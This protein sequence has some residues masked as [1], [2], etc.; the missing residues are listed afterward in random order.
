MK[1]EI[2]GL[3]GQRISKEQATVRRISPDRAQVYVK[4]VERYAMLFDRPEVRLRFLNNMI[5]KQVVRQKKLQHALRHFRF[6]ERTRLYDILLDVRF[7]R[8]IM[9]ELSASAGAVPIHRSKYFRNIR[10]PLTARTGFFCYQFRHAIYGTGLML[11]LLMVFGMYSLVGWSVGRVDKLL[12]KYY[13]PGSSEVLRQG[14][15]AAM[16]R[17][18]RPKE[19]E[20]TPAKLEKVWFLDK[21]GN[22]ERWSNRA[23][24]RTE[25]ETENRPRRFYAIPRGSDTAP[26]RLRSDIVGIVYHTSESHI[27]PY[28]PGYSEDIVRSSRGVINYIRN[29]KLYNYLIDRSG[30]IYRIVR[31]EH[32]ANHSGHSIWADSNYAY[33]GLN[34]SFIGICFESTVNAD[35]KEILTEPQI[36]SGKELTDVL[37]NKYNIDDANCTTHGL[38]SIKP[39]RML[40]AFHHDWVRD[41]PF[42]AMGLSDKYKVPPP[43]I[44]DYGFTYDDEILAKLNG[45]LWEGAIIAEAEFKKRAEQAII[46]PQILRENLRDRYLTQYYAQFNKSPI[47]KISFTSEEPQDKT[48]GPSFITRSASSKM[49][50]GSSRKTKPGRRRR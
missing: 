1:T 11:A 46:D 41:F 33:V 17:P 20:K 35:S 42:E 27:V 29:N 43:N 10:I 22:I 14:E 28:D 9:E 19:A 23:R 45:K 16:V 38:V 39:E 49:I 21:K 18:P 24:I 37:R 34:E 4:I 47:D 13:R 40:V 31:D 12:A 26:D 8:S 5:A 2:I 36:L 32:A 50:V 3:Q 7:Y 48:S 6:V 44:S 25:F 30:D 15:A